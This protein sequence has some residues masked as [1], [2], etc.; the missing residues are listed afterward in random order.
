MPVLMSWLQVK[1]GSVILMCFSTWSEQNMRRYSTGGGKLP[2]EGWCLT[3]E[4]DLY[5]VAIFMGIY[6]MS[7]QHK[8]KNANA[9]DRQRLE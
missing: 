8:R 5:A 6:W 2:P 7:I 3:K 1:R 9:I 4:G